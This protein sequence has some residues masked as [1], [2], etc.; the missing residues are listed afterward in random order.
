MARPE[1][2]LPPGDSWWLL[3]AGRGFGKTRAGSEAIKKLVYTGYRRICLIG[4][5]FQ[6]V[7]RVMVEG[8]SGLMQVSPEARYYP[9]LG[10]IVWPNG[11]EAQIFTAENPEALRGPQFDCAWLD[12]FLKFKEPQLVWDQLMMT[13]RLGR[14]RLIITSTPRPI[15][16]LKQLLS[17]PK[18]FVTRGTTFDNMKNLAPAFLNSIRGYEGTPFARQEIYG[19]IVTDIAPLWSSSWIQYLDE[20]PVLEEV[21]IAIDPAVSSHQTSDE[22][23]MIVLGRSAGKFYVLHDHSKRGSVRDWVQTAIELYYRYG[24]R[25]IIIETNQGGELTKTLLLQLDP[26]LSI[27]EVRASKSKYT[28]AYQ[29]SILYL[30]GLVYH[31]KGLYQLE[32]QMLNFENLSGSPD[33]VDALVWGLQYLSQPACKAYVI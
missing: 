30:Q 1:Q 11:A 28:R 23:G 4:A 8:E 17:D 9:S 24:A 13:L 16:I 12:E 7:R 29:A 21:I 5:T 26:R 22:T 14:P 32:E 25:K 18:I 19:E 6:E 20:M 3:L 2:L 33:R 31:A 10:S 27:Y 15:P